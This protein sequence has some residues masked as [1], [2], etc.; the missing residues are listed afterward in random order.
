MLVMMKALCIQYNKSIHSPNISPPRTKTKIVK[1]GW[2]IKRAA[3]NEL[4]EHS[5]IQK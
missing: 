5:Q 3:Q 1:Q 2:L 4:G